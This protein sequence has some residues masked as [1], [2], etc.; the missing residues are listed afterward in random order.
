MSTPEKLASATMGKYE[1]VG[2]GAVGGMGEVYAVRHR[3]LQELRA[4]KIMRGADAP[5]RQLQERFILEARLSARLR[6][7]NLVQ[8]YDL[9]FHE[10][11]TVYMVLEWIE[12]LDL[13]KVLQQYGPPPLADALSIA[14]QAVRALD[15]LHGEGVVHRDIAADNLMIAEK[16][17]GELEVKLIDLGIAKSIS[18][19]SGLTRK[20]LFVGKL[21]YAAPETLDT[22]SRPATPDPRSDL[23][24][25]GIVLYEL[26]TGDSPIVG[27]TES[28]ILAAHLFGSPRD[29]AEADPGGR[30]PGELRRIV[31]KCLERSPAERFQSAAEVS[32]A[33]ASVGAPAARP[34]RSTQ[35]R[36]TITVARELLRDLARPADLEH[37]QEEF[38]RTIESDLPVPAASTTATAPGGEVSAEREIWFDELRRGY[39]RRQRTTRFST[40]VQLIRTHPKPAVVAAMAVLLL[41]VV[42]FGGFLRGDESAASLPAA[43][44]A[45]TPAAET[46]ERADARYPGSG[47]A[48]AA[49]EAAAESPALQEEAPPEETVPAAE[50]APPATSSAIALVSNNAQLTSALLE[51]LAGSPE[52]IVRQSLGEAMAAARLR[53]GPA[54]AIQLTVEAQPATL[55]AYE[56]TIPTCRVAVSGQVL[57]LPRGG[58]LFA[59]SVEATAPQC[60]PAIA[61]AGDQ[62]ARQLVARVRRLE[63][64]R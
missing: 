4:V 31:L 23:Y 38:N 2:A 49:D 41:V 43:A 39:V 17:G 33:L 3:L 1:F 10:D 27:D 42:G 46:A 51:R 25:F 60:G 11:G 64:G 6:H 13:A 21:R 22:K 24:S 36:R 12:G 48:T 32:R 16:P 9:A 62:L 57:T 47:P 52:V 5:N 63:T 19:D 58:S 34:E 59:R 56:T 18:T 30:V 37:E 15:Y 50:A 35:L 14:R 8:L 53:G 7:P 45:E 20:G 55:E 54:H 40:V 26:F 61:L 44:D 28:E 29:F